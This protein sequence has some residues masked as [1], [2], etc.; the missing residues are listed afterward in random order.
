[1]AR[2]GESLISYIPLSEWSEHRGYN[3][4]S[5]EQGHHPRCATGGFLRRTGYSQPTR[6]CHFGQCRFVFHLHSSIR[7]L[8]YTP[9]LLPPNS[10]SV[11]QTR[12]HMEPFCWGSS[13]QGTQ[14]S[15]SRL[16]IQRLPWSIFSARRDAVTSSCLRT[17]AYVIWPAK[18]WL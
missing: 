11:E 1:M 8:V 18:Y 13:V 5:D 4:C 7:P 12:S 15:Q 17:P 9:S 3:L 16:A 6:Y 14:R 10:V 2:P